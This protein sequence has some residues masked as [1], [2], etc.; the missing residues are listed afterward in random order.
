MMLYAEQIAHAL[1][2]GRTMDRIGVTLPP[3]VIGRLML[4]GMNADKDVAD[5]NDALN[6][7]GGLLGMDT[8]TPKGRKK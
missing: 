2:Q 8:P 7:L 1:A 5:K 6:T 3:D 4:V